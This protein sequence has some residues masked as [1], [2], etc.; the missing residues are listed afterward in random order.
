M[1]AIIIKITFAISNTFNSIFFKKLYLVTCTMENTQIQLV[2]LHSVCIPDPHQSNINIFLKSPE[3]YADTLKKYKHDGEIAYFNSSAK[4]VI[5]HKFSLGNDFQEI[6]YMI[7]VWINEGSGWIV[8]S[9]ESQYINISTYRPLSGSSYISL[10]ER[11]K[12]PKK[13]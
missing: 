4:T 7:D 8:E 10:P 13:D 6:F 11:L 2:Q 12:S 5:R 9:I 3:E 1:I